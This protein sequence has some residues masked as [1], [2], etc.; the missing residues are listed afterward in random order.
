MPGCMLNELLYLILTAHL[1]DAWGVF[2]IKD[3]EIEYWKGSVT[4][5]RPFKY[6]AISKHTVLFF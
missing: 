1:R 5:P 6:S 2:L 3:K 4:H